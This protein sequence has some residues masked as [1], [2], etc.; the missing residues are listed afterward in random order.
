MSVLWGRAQGRGAREGCEGGQC[1]DRMCL[2]GEDSTGCWVRHE[3]S[4]R[5]LSDEW[6]SGLSHWMKGPITS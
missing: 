1:G 6:I 3:N 4:H 5:I 2:E